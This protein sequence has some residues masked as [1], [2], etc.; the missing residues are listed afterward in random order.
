[1]KL[2]LDDFGTGVS[3]FGYLRDINLDLVRVDRN[4]VSE[5]L[6]SDA[7]RAICKNIVR[8]AHD[9]ELI[10]IAEGVETREQADA[11]YKMGVDLAQGYLYGRPETPEQIE[12]RLRG[13]ERPDDG[14]WDPSQVLDFQGDA[15]LTPS[16]SA[17]G[18]GRTGP[19]AS[20]VADRALAP[21]FRC[22]GP[23]RRHRS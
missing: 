5:V 14:T 12:D 15:L 18:S 21:R 2:G 22:D 23:H 9:L 1:M 20:T 8:L 7:D 19:A 17:G 4:F 11:L 16:R 13:G 3:S 10:A 6:V